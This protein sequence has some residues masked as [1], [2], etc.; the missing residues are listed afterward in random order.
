MNELLAFL[1]VFMIGVVVGAAGMC[2]VCRRV[3]Q[4]KRI[5]RIEHKLSI[6]FGDRKAD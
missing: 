1:V 6:L 4:L 2:T 5:E 3:H